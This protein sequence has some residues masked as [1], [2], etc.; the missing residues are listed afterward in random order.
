MVECFLA[1]S[2]GGFLLKPHS[3]KNDPLIA[4]AR[5]RGFWPT[6]FS[7]VAVVG[8]AA[9]LLAWT[10]IEDG[11]RHR[12][13]VSLVASE[14]GALVEAL[15]HAV[16]DALASSREVEELAAARLLDIARLLDRLDAANRLDSESLEN[17]AADLGLHYILML[18]RGFR[19]EAEACPDDPSGQ[20]HRSPYVSALQPLVEGKADELVLGTREAPDGEGMRYAAAVR[21]TRGG[22]LLVVMD[23]RQ[24]LAFEEEVGASNIMN[25]VADTGGILYAVLEDSE[26]RQ[27][28]GTSPRAVAPTARAL[29]LE[30]PVEVRRGQLGRLR[31]GLAADALD[32]AARSGRRRT[33]AAALVAFALAMAVAGVVTARRRAAALRAETARA[34]SLTDAVL[35][36]IGDAVVVVDPDGILRLVNPAACRLFGRSAEELVGKHCRETP[37]ASVSDLLSVSPRA[38]ELAVAHEG[39]GSPTEVLASAS[40]VRDDAGETA[41]TALVLRDLTDVRR[42]EREARRTESLTAFG[43]LAA[44]VAHEVR[45]PLNAIS[46]GVQRIQ[47]EFSP[48]EGAEDHRRLTGVLRTEIERLDGIV[49]GFLDLARPPHLEPKPGDL[50]S[51]VRETVAL[52]AEGFS[53]GPR[54]SVATGGVPQAVFDQGA[55]RQILHNLIRNAVEA[56]GDQGKVRIETGVEGTHV[57]LDVV[58]DGPGIPPADLDRVFE[59][60]FTTKPAGNGL[61]LPI[62]HRLVAEMGGSV[63]IGPG[64]GGGTVVRVM[65]PLASGPAA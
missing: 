17:L 44:A 48:V 35:E 4:S 62:V 13:M 58:D 53:A 47:K 15:G 42:L 43:R 24:M 2:E 34:R 6:A 5:R 30:R 36:G 55:I 45:N 22:A 46:V 38:C 25:A 60:G 64:P 12:E 11:A 18:D 26:G 39:G 19:R 20:P 3:A 16:E 14:G 52:L 49:R 28:A 8:F 29:E 65:L 9:L 23:A 51:V 41:G 61:G 50:D 7:A 56:T 31:V 57:F 10:E 1:R 59:F 21:R 54:L 33:A 63:G 27:V 40:P 37:C 32:A